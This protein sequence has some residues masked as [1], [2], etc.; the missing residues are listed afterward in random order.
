MNKQG[1]TPLGI[2]FVVAITILILGLT[3]TNFLMTEVTT[4][5]LPNNL[6]C[7]NSTISDG[8][9]LLCLGI[10]LTIP[11]YIWIILSGTVGVIIFKYL[12]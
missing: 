2:A 1:Q 4:A 8:N 5:R 6:D 12:K 3:I 9:K 11:L 7:S 10:D